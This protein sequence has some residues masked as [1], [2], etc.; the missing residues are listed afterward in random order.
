[1]FLNHSIKNNFLFEILKIL[2]VVLS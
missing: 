2:I 1:V